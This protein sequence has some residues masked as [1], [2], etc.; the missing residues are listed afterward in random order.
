MHSSRDKVV[1]ILRGVG[2][3][4]VGFAGPGPFSTVEF[5]DEWLSKGYH[6]EMGYLGRNPKRR[7]NPKEIREWTQSVIVVALDY[8]T[9]E[10]LSTEVM[11][12]PGRGWISRY[13]WGEDYHDVIESKFK[14][15][16]DALVAETGGQFRYYVDHG[17]VMEK[18]AGAAAG[19]GW[20]GKN[21]LLIHPK[22]GSWFFLGVLLTDVEFEADGIVADHCGSCTRCLDVCPTQAFPEPYVLDATRCISYLTIE[23]KGELDPALREGLGS[24]VFGCDLC[25]DVCPWNRKAPVV[26]RE[27]FS[28]REGFMGPNLN[29][30]KDWN[31]DEFR[32]RARKSPLKRRKYTGILENVSHALSNESRKPEKGS[33]TES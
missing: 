1:E 29:T 21:T 31:E 22:A 20:V 12:Q 14:A 25:Q 15:A 17:P 16:H 8:H 28:P 13:A 9:G 7:Q 5:L 18:P 32:L 3:D 4:R 26:D 6:G 19:L 2:F 10:P 24:H 30:W 11:D 33:H 23:R 27:E